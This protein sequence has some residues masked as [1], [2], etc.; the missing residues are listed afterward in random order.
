M[1]ANSKKRRENGAIKA[2]RNYAEEEER[3]KKEEKKL[4]RKIDE[5]SAVS[6]TSHI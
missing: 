3:N 1:V 5:M 2:K 4:E 6:E